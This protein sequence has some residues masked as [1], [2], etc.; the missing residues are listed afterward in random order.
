M[1]CA[2]SDYVP[3]LLNPTVP[4]PVNAAAI[5]EVKGVW[6]P[7]DEH[8][9]D[10]EIRYYDFLE[11]RDSPK[12]ENE[13]ADPLV[14]LG[15]YKVGEPSQ[16]RMKVECVALSLNKDEKWAQKLNTKEQNMAIKEKQL[17][18]EEME[19]EREEAACES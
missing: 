3:L 10:Q 18:M 4:L 15:P 5:E 6:K 19:R 2:S 1:V 9:V 11:E 8:D 14:L 13:D 17:A 12:P 7:E 16:Q